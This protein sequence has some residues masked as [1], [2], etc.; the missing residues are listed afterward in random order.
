MKKEL[1]KKANTDVIENLLFVI[2]NLIFFVGML[3][4]INTS[5]SQTFIYEE[6]YAKQIA[7]LID[8]AK[9]GMAVS[10][11]IDELKK[12]ADENNQAVSEIFSVENKNNKISVDLDKNQGYSYRYYSDYDVELNKDRLEEGWLVIIVKERG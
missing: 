12:I 4:F 5:G 6:A 8:N 1:G 7:L 2:L 10:M 9:P 3:V 11:K